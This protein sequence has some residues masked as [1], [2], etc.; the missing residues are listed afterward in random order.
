MP[1]LRE[2][3]GQIPFIDVHTH[4]DAEHITARGLSDVL[5]Y[6]MVVS[7]L[8][9]AGC[10]DGA[11]LSE[12]PDEQEAERRIERALDYLPYIRYTSCYYGVKRILR[13]L[14]G[15]EEELT[16]DNWRRADAL[17]RERYG[18][19]AW[20][21]EILKRAGVEKVNTE[22]CRRGGGAWDGTLFY[23]L[24]WAFFTRIQHRQ[25]DTAL[26][27]LE[28]AWTEQGVGKPLPVNI[29]PAKLGAMKRIR[30]LDDIET[31]LDHTIAHIPLEDIAGM[32]T[33]Y[34]SYIHYRPV[35]A[36][37]MA[38]ALKRRAVAREAER[39]IYA[40]Y[41]ADRF[42]EK[43]SVLQGRGK[44][45]IGVSVGAEPLDFET[46]C[47]LDA[48]TLFTLAELAA[49]HPGID[50]LV[51]N[52]CESLDQTLCTLIRETPNLYA[53]GYWWHNF[54]PHAISSVFTR[55]IDM[56]PTNKWFGFFSDAYCLDWCYAKS[57]IVRSVM[58]DALEKRVQS[59][60]I[61]AQ[62]AIALV[63]TLCYDNAVRYYGLK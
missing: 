16:K 6:H 22:L 38:S 11:R 27:E 60:L 53:A 35:P 14:Y 45:R 3:I 41:I 31:A 48:D 5:L 61:D 52:A 17:I 21:R 34:S 58:A 59:G 23:S 24:E 44:V 43:L 62:G 49:K 46:G 33:H 15:W 56:L 42:Y 51:F 4:I 32:P 63:K 19:P 9:S 30:T 57:Q 7:E 55:R 29:D 40:N 54:F 18:D 39:D 2:R 26:V 37:E 50:I 28:A 36:K 1:D 8:Y 20:A 25:Y 12:W 47:R 13:D 10:P